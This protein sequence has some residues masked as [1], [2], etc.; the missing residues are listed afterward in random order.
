MEYNKT[1]RRVLALIAF[2]ALLLAALLL[3]PLPKAKKVRASRIHQG[4][5]TIAN[6]FITVPGTNALP[7]A[8]SN[9]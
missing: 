3:T 1:H 2:I 5:N 6:P 8:T 7:T 9:K 4:V